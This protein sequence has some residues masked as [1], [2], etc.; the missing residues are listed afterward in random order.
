V[1][2][3][4]IRNRSYT[5]TRVRCS[6][7]FAAATKAVKTWNLTRGGKVWRTGKFPAGSRTRRFR[8]PRVRKLAKGIYVLR[9]DG[10]RTGITIRIKG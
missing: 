10:R 7:E 1:N 4:V 5:V 6:V 8:V 3:R 2:C 9:V